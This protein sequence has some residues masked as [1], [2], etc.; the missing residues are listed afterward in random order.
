MPLML[1]SVSHQAN[2]VINGTIQL[3]RSRWPKG[4][5]H[6]FWSCDACDATDTSITIMWCHWHQHHHH[7]MPMETSMAP[8]HL[9]S[10]Y[11]QNKV[12]NWHWCWHCLMPMASKTATL[13]SLGQDNWSQMQHD[14]WLFDAIGTGISVT[15]CQQHHQQYHCF[16]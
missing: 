16:P 6:D 3:V 15:S 8:L 2:G 10:Q 7:V 11:N 5:G 14:F 4:D 13:Y 12:Q 1:V 9:F